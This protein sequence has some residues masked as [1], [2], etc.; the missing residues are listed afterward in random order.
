M[1]R[2]VSKGEEMSEEG[3]LNN[4]FLGEIVKIYEYLTTEYP[5][6]TVYFSEYLKAPSCCIEDGNYVYEW[7]VAE[8]SIQNDEVWIYHNR[9]SKNGYEGMGYGEKLEDVV[10]QVKKFLQGKIK[11]PMKQT[12]IFDFI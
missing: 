12:T 10:S 3:I 9:D 4:K 2:F 11:V 6:N 7:H 8:N 5:Q 1:T